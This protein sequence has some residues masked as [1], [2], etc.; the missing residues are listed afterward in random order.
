MFSLFPCDWRQPRPKGMEDQR[1]PF[2]KL[3]SKLG[4]PKTG[5]IPVQTKGN[6]PNAGGFAGKI[7]AKPANGAIPECEMLQI[8]EEI[9]FTE[10]DAMLEQL[11]GFGGVAGKPAK[12]TTDGQVMRAIAAVK[13]KIAKNIRALQEPAGYGDDAVSR[14]EVLKLLKGFAE[15]SRSLEGYIRDAMRRKQGQEQ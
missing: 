9:D 7:G 2:Q 11:G 3:I 14:D 12:E 13:D 10:I 8:G 1:S 5:G 4:S 15:Y 6:A